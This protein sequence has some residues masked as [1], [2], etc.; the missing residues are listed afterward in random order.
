[1]K[2]LVIAV[3]AVVVAV[4]LAACTEGDT[5]ACTAADRG[6]VAYVL[7]THA[8]RPAVASP[9]LLDDA[10]D[11]Q[12]TLAVVR[13]DGKPE[14][15][16]TADLVSRAPG[17]DARNKEVR[18]RKAD[19]RAK[20]SSVRPTTAELDLLAAIELG[21]RSLERKPKTMVVESSGLSTAGALSFGKPGMLMAAPKE[22]ADA[23]ERGGHLPILG[24]IRVTLR[25]LGD[26][27]P[28]QQVLS[29]PERSNLIA[30]WK[31]VLTRAG[32]DVQPPDQRPMNGPAWTEVPPVATVPVTPA[33]VDLGR[34]EDRETRPLPA[35]A[36]FVADSADLL[37]RADAVEVLRLFAEHVRRSGGR[38]D[39]VGTTARVGDRSGQVS[40]STDR[41]NAL[42]TLLVDELGVP[43]DRV[44]ASGVG[45]FHP[46]YVVDH[47]DQGHLLP[48]KAAL[49][50]TVRVTVHN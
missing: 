35:A 8:N 49:N 46:D 34:L 41:A 24:G 38:L 20:L 5:C 44:G 33:S 15:V 14:V 42:R 37:D 21:A 39:L 6:S 31:E 2:T 40:L 10:V 22:V 4:V 12:A 32:A 45:S 18:D 50:R 3:K 13:A 48:D 43:G 7:G 19:L 25:G 27:M 1:M 29:T 23:L 16:I 30:I 17:P 36:F 47:D 26:V 28:P 9:D 11:R